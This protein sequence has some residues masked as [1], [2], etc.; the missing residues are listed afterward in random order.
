MIF[1]LRDSLNTC[2]SWF[3]ILHSFFFKTNHI[4]NKKVKG[5][6]SFIKVRMNN[7]LRNEWRFSYVLLVNF[8]FLIFLLLR[9]YNAMKDDSKL[10]IIIV[11]ITNNNRNKLIVYFNLISFL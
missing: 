2:L 6:K 4:V 9:H 8:V 10:I 7:K 11:S 1:R 5:L 3:E